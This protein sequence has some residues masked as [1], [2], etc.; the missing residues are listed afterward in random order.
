MGLLL[1][2]VKNV[3]YCTTIQKSCLRVIEKYSEAPLYGHLLNKDSLLNV[4]SVLG[5]TLKIKALN[6]DTVIQTLCGCLQLT[7]FQNKNKRNRSKVF[8][9]KY[10]C[11]DLS[12]N[13][14]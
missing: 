4:D 10:I 11:E 7:V 14:Q 2:L 13:F 8:L 3:K 12:T 9:F 5:P 1:S 6:K